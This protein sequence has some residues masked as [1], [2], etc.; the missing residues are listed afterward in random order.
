MPNPSRVVV[1]VAGKVIA[2]TAMALTLRESLVIQRFS[3]SPS[4]RRYGRA[5]SQR[6]TTYCPYKGAASYYSIPLAGIV[7]QCRVDLRDPF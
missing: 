3:T 2:D 6:H 5:H 4:G 1:T 7:P